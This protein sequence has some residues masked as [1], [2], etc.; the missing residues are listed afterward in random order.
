MHARQGAHSRK[1]SCWRYARGMGG[2]DMLG[3]MRS[4]AFLDDQEK[5]SEERLRGGR[6]LFFSAQG[7]KYAVLPLT[8]HAIAVLAHV[9]LCYRRC[10]PGSIVPERAT[11][12]AGC[13]ACQTRGIAGP[14]SLRASLARKTKQ[15]QCLMRPIEFSRP[16]SFFSGRA[17]PDKRGSCLVFCRRPRR[18]R[19]SGGGGGAAWQA[20]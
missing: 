18:R 19:R 13:F 8:G 20:R 1:L 17:V 11:T 9:K 4:H 6:W 7:I 16:T 2:G 3:N 10:K 12:R 15:L 14:S 5:R